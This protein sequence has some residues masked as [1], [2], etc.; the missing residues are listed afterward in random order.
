MSIFPLHLVSI[1]S[2]IKELRGVSQSAHTL[3]KWERLKRLTFQIDEQ[4]KRRR[5]N[6][7]EL[8]HPEPNGIRYL[9][10]AET[11]PEID[12][13]HRLVYELGLVSSAHDWMNRQIDEHPVARDLDLSATGLHITAI[14]R[15]DRFID[16]LLVS[17]VNDGLVQRLCRHASSLTLNENGWPRHFPTNP[18][19]SIQSG[20][21]VK[22]LDGR[23]EGRTTGGRRACP[24]HHCNGWLVGVHWQTGQRL[25]ICTEGW[26]YDPDNRQI[27]VIGG[28]VISARF[29][30]PKP[31]GTPPLPRSQW[32]KR[33]ELLKSRAWA[34]SGGVSQ[35]GRE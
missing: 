21:V 27:R 1:L 19:G 6:S 8:T 14:F 10:S 29:V 30:S 28:G 18:D 16:G 24:S 20:L 33:S 5:L 15:G 2:F 26:H 32:P 17:K 7:T 31:Y 25:H 11:T 22:S 3:A 23:I 35:G 4:L 13:L 34:A 9:V 12:E